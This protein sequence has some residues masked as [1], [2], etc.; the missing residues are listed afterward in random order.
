MARFIAD[1]ESEVRHEVCRDPRVTVAQFAE[2]ARDPVPDIRAH[3]VQHLLELLSNH[4]NSKRFTVYSTFYEEVASIILERC[5]DTD[6]NVRLVIANGMDAPPQGLNI[7]FDDP[8]PEVQRAVHAHSQ[9]PFGAVLDFEKK[10]PLFGINNSRHGQTTPS[11][12]LI[13]EFTQGDNTFLRYIAA[14]SARTSL[15]DLR[16]LVDDP[17]PAIRDMAAAKIKLRTAKIQKDKTPPISQ[18]PN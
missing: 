9:W 11:S 2:L 13:H 8:S 10:H 18:A 12:L 14:Q 5:R 15:F 4:R 7:L 6:P 1:P 3:V 16:A 17:H